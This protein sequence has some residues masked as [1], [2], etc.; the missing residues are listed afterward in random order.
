MVLVV[1]LARGQARPV[2]HTVVVCSPGRT[3]ASAIAGLR[4]SAKARPHT[5]PH[6]RMLIIDGLANMN[7]TL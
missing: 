2:G 4:A 1:T 6:A 5:P 3:R 7:F